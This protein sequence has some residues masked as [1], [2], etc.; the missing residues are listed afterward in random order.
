MDQPTRIICAS[1]ALAEGGEGV[2]FVIHH[3][4]RD[5]PGFVIRY[6]GKVHGYINNCAHI[7]VEMDWPEGEFF[8]D[9]GL[10]LMCSV[11]GA[12]YEPD[13]G[14]CT[15]GPCKGDS[16]IPLHVYEHDGNIYLTES[17]NHHG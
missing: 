15:M 10:Y 14:H 7:P 6:D 9:S 12:T 3:R 1:T 11:H 4:G 2:K 16:L 8:D 13:T 5:E 17:G